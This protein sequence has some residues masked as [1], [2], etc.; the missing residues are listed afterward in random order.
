M[1]LWHVVIAFLAIHRTVVP[2]TDTHSSLTHPYPC[3]SMPSEDT[4]TPGRGSRTPSPGPVQQPSS[5]P[6]PTFDPSPPKKRGGQPMST[7]VKRQRL[8]KKA[9][10]KEQESWTPEQTAA[11]QSRIMQQKLAEVAVEKAARDAAAAAKADRERT[12]RVQEA[13]RALKKAGCQSTYQFFDDFFSS[14]DSEISKQ[15]SR[16]M[17]D[18]GTDLLDLLHAKRPAIVERWALKVS[19]P[20]IAAE[21]ANLVA[22]LSPDPT[23]TFTSRLETWSLEKMLAEA[24]IA[25]PNLCEL[26]MLMGMTSDVGREDNKL[27]LVTVLSM[28]AQAQNERSNE[29][30]ATMGT[31][32]LACST[33]RRQFDVLAHAGLTVSYTTAITNLK[34]LSAEG[35]L[36]LRRMV[37]EKACM[38]VWDNLN[39][40]FKV[41]EQR[42]NS[43]DTFENGTTA[44]LIV[45]YGVLRGELELELLEPRNS[46][47]PVLSFE[48]MDTL[49]NVEQIIQT[50]RSALWHVRRTFLERY[51]A[52]AAK[53][54]DELGDI[55]V[56]QAIPLHKSEHFPTPAMKIDES[57]LDGTIDV[58]DTMITR[59]LQLDAAGMRAH[60]VMFAGGDLLSL[61]LTDKAIAARREDT[62]LL[63]AYGKY[64]TGMLGLFHVKLSGTRGTVNEHWGEP[65]SKFPG[66][67]WSQNSFLSRK[68]IPAGWKAKKLP[69]FRPTYELML[70]LSLPAHILDGFRIYCGAESLDAWAES[71]LSWSRI[72]SV[73]E[74]VVEKLCSAGTVEELRLLPEAERDPQLENTILCNHDMLL[75]LLFTTSIKS[76]DVGMVVNILAHWMV[77]FRGTGSMP[78][79][80][81]AL[82]ELINNLKR[83]PPA[84]RDAYLNNWLVNLSGKIKAFKE[85]D[86]LQEHQNFWAKVIYNARGSNRSWDW[87]SMITVVIFNLRDVMRNVQTQFKIPHHGI[88]HTSPNAAVDIAN[89]QGW[90]E[91]NK[92]QTYVKERPGKDEIIRV[93]DLMVTGAAYANT[94]GA[95]KNFRRE[96]RKVSYKQVSAASND[97]ESDEEEETVPQED[98]QL[99]EVVQDDLMHDDEDF[100]HMADDLLNMAQDVVGIM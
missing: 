56:I 55:P 38:I 35:L 30:Q 71:D 6:N 29:F 11:E 5:G 9:V 53:F 17:H 54:K 18:H 66:S 59:T 96:T 67:L 34:G 31:Y 90:L 44:T 74:M 64:L 60:G 4:F 22:A 93:R 86:L 28:L 63:D 88:S 91:L 37:Q 85:I 41:G 95:F 81:D 32:F 16:L 51:P 75:L 70:T 77:M 98:T 39:I 10:A 46:R 24:T 23:K 25:A 79:Y 15:A 40:A 36:R 42:H 65:N 62:E 45:L 73:S 50:R 99:D 76:G 84:L 1:H 58:I 26:L 7:K 94:P 12:V 21:G 68:S 97:S 48:P 61:N 83:W 33:P 87:L 49:P 20:V 78:K 2:T 3:L 19:L 27:V 8:D 82:F 72:E 57:S 80:A 92:L 100:T 69:P 14:T 13:L 89:L 52:L 43:K 47:K